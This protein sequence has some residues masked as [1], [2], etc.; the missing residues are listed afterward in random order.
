MNILP[1][2]T[3]PATSTVDRRHSPSESAYPTYRPCLRWEFGFSCAFCL[4]HEADLVEHGAE[5]TT[6]TSIEHGVPQSR[7]PSGALVNRY[8]NCFYSCRFCNRARGFVPNMDATGRRLLDPCQD[9]WGAHFTA[10]DDRLLPRAGDRDATRTY[11]AYDL[12]DERKRE[13]RR[14]REEVLRDAFRVLVEGAECSKRLLKIAARTSAPDRAVI[15]DAA[16]QIR[17]K[18]ARARRDLVRF[19]AVPRDADPICRCPSPAD[20]CLLPP[21]LE[22]QL[23]PLPDGADDSRPG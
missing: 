1:D 18:M 10:V 12:D 15:M 2:R 3:A 5:G 17:E 8:T 6:L 7:D 14:T 13:M 23:R 4:V 9:A 22:A 21:F 20:T 11:Y 19:S 16:R